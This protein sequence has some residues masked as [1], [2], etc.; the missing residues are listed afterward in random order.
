MTE[1]KI[2]IEFD[3]GG[4]RDGERISANDLPTEV[5]VTEPARWRTDHVYVHQGRWRGNTCIY[6]YAGMVEAK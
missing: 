4:P 6:Q 2:I 1:A 5:R 3:G